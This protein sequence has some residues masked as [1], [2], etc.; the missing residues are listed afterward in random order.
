MAKASTSTEG[1]ASAGVLGANAIKELQ[2]ISSRI[3]ALEGQ[4]ADVMEDLKEVY[5]SAKDAGFDTKILRKAIR[6]IKRD[7]GERQAEEDMVDSYVHAI[8]QGDLFEQAA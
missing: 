8:K 2:E 6:L 1:L 5:N 7:A 3:I 4:K